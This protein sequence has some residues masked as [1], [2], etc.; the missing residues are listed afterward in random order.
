MSF[1]TAMFNVPLKKLIRQSTK[2][3][4]KIAELA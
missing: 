1:S 4:G 2:A 3:K